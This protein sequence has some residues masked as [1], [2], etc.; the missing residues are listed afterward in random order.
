[1]GEVD[2]GGGATSCTEAKAEGASAER[3]ATSTTRSGASSQVGVS[4]DPAA[5][6]LCALRASGAV[7][8]AVVSAMLNS[9]WP[10]CPIPELVDS[11]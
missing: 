5:V 6:A 2:V 11:C 10:A 8:R 4:S 3:G 7:S 9:P 1:M